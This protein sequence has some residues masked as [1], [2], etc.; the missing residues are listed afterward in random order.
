MKPTKS[1]KLRGLR[2][3][4]KGTAEAEAGSGTVVAEA[5]SGSRSFLASLLGCGPVT[6]GNAGFY[7]DPRSLKRLVNNPCAILAPFAIFSGFFKTKSIHGVLKN[8]MFFGG[9]SSLMSL[10]CYILGKF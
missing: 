3:S 4:A 10:P 8:A 2:R 1:F 7:G 9:I 5:G 6:V